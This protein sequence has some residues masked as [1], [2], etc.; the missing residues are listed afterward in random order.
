[1]SLFGK[2]IKSN[3]CTIIT[4][5]DG[6]NPPVIAS[7]NEANLPFG[8]TF[9][10]NN[11]A[12]FAKNKHTEN[13]LSPTYWKMG[14]SSFESFFKH[15]GE[16]KTKS[17]R[18]TKSVLDE[19]DNLKTVILNIRPQVSAG[20]FKL[21][22]LQTQLNIF[23]E[24]KNEIKKNETFEYEVE[25]IVQK[26][27]DLPKG[28]HVTNC[29]NCNVTCH[30][31][32]KIPDDDDKRYCG[33][34]DMTTG[35]CRICPDKC[36][37][38]IHKNTPVMF[39]YVTKK[40]KKTYADVKKRHEDALGRTLTH[41]KYIEELTLD[42]DEMFE[43]INSMMDQMNKCKSRLKE[44]ALKPDPL[45][46]AEHIDLMIQSEEAEKQN[47]YLKRIQMLNEFKRMALVDQDVARF[48][49]NI[50]GAKKSIRKISGSPLSK[51]Y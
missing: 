20:L 6:A 12:L 26:V 1:M 35:F 33:A 31:N 38:S 19:R 28:Q 40:V 47:G 7:L 24:F 50:E 51:R 32:C 27:I 39:D 45:T 10:F 48:G 16:M 34:M 37:W 5:A 3:I 41:E 11:S 9:T 29:I 43:K 42:L 49:Q 22:E 14:C 23:E 21:S 25:E 2:D 18:Q 15:L 46:T 4:F 36:I 17:L 44:I 13:K 8:S 30:R